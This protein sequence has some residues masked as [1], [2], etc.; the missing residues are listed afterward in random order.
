MLAASIGGSV[1]KR[2]LLASFIAATGLLTGCVTGEYVQRSGERGDYYHGR[3]SVDYRYHD[4][5]YGVHPYGRF[6]FGFGSP[7]YRSPYYPYSYYG[8]YYGYPYYNPYYYNPPRHRPR[9][10]AH[11]GTG[12][13]GERRSPWRALIGDE[14]GTRPSQERMVQPR[15]PRSLP[16]REPRMTPREDRGGRMQDILRRSSGER[17]RPRVSDER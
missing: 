5:P 15:E 12:T 4:A 7:Y 14:G 6:E 13:P 16:S 10:P 2:A 1:M 17:A 11:P 8:P 9:P 3:P